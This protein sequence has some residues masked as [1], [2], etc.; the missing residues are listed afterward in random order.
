[1]AISVAAHAVASSDDLRHQVGCASASVPSTKKVA[2]MP[3]S[4]SRSK[5]WGVVRG[6]GPSSKVSATASPRGPR[7]RH[8]PSGNAWSRTGAH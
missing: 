6:E 7:Q 5:V 8:H 3:S 1:M 2:R 4:S